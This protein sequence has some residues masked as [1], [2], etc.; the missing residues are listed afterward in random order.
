MALDIARLLLMPVDEL[1]VSKHC[2]TLRVI[3]FKFLGFVQDK[4]C[5]QLL[6]GWMLIAIKLQAAHD[7]GQMLST[8]IFIPFSREV[9]HC[10]SVMP[11]V[12][13]RHVTL[14]PLEIRKLFL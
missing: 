11:P 8:D 9:R 12:T 7:Y 4:L 3:S 13:C 14:L 1:A 2:V 6:R 5:E 10:V